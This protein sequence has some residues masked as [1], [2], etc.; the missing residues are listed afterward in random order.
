M[1]FYIELPADEYGNTACTPAV[2]AARYYPAGREPLRPMDNTERPYMTVTGPPE[3]AAKWPSMYAD[4]YGGFAET[5]G[6]ARMLSR[7]EWK[8]I[9]GNLRTA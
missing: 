4:S 2:I 7:N 8:T 5:E 9:T 1:K 6:P 3:F